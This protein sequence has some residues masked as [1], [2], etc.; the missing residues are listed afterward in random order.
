MYSSQKLGTTDLGISNAKYIESGIQEGIEIKGAEFKTLPSGKQLFEITLAQ[1][2][3]T[4]TSSEWE[5]T[6]YSDETD[7]DFKKRC[8]GHLERLTKILECYYDRSMLVVEASDFE[9]LFNW[10][11]RML[12]LADKTKKLRGKF[13]YNKDGF[14]V[15]KRS[16]KP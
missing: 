12:Q 1:G 5:T 11:N 16:K 15:F 14:I 3:A 6:R 13:T 8:L 7:E 4:A 10:F 9:G 2:E